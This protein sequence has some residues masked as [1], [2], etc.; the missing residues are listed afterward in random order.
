MK[1]CWDEPKR[2]ANLD[3]HALDFADLTFGFF[4]TALVLEARKP[5]WRAIG[6]LGERVAVA[7]FAPLGSEA[8]SVISLRHASEKERLSFD[9]RKARR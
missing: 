3:K 2:R 4:E 7:I 5:R 6:S 8:I 9:E 1:I